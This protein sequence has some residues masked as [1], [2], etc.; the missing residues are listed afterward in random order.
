MISSCSS[1]G[2]HTPPHRTQRCL[3]SDAGNAAATG[4]SE[5][6]GDAR[7][8]TRSAG[9]AGS[10]R[11]I[12]WTAA[13]STERSARGSLPTPLHSRLHSS[14]K[15]RYRHAALCCSC[16]SMRA[17]N[18]HARK[19]PMGDALTVRARTRRCPPAAAASAAPRPDTDLLSRILVSATSS[20]PP[21]HRSPHVGLF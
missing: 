17:R 2:R 6:G 14:S 11:R 10:T 7:C 8:A 16:R 19:G 12:P 20:P 3:H 1:R 9:T 21:H 5:K 15:G 13:E 4:R 18:A